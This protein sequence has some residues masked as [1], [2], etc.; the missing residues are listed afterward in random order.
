MLARLVTEVPEADAVPGGYVYEPKW[1]GFRCVVMRDG[2]QI[3]LGSRM[4]RSLTSY[5]PE[6]VEHLREHL[7]PRCAIDTELIVPIGRIGR[8]HLDWDALSDRL[9]PSLR[10]IAKL[11]EQTPAELVAFDVLA[12]E[13]RDLRHEPLSVRRRVLEDVFDAINP[14]SGLHVTAQTHSAEQAR[15]WFNGFDGYGLDGLVVKE[16]DGHYES[17]RRSWLKVKRER[18]AEV[19]VLGYRRTVRHRG[20]GRLLLGMYGADDETLYYVG[21]VDLLPEHQRL[22]FAAA[23]EDSRLTPDRQPAGIL[24]VPGESA[25]ARDQ[26]VWLRPEHVAEVEFD[27]LDGQQFR[28][29]ARFRRW[30][31][32][33]DARTCRLD[34]LEGQS[35]YDLASVLG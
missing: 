14:S 12:L 4:N 30:R 11:A 35:V 31:P 3:E 26:T 8:Q 33:R 25:L 23:L 2:D 7:P 24:G 22:E 19:V 29:A 21:C 13:D 28:H 16:W 18:T 20:V 9:H 6:V 32:D 34:Q 15:A 27:Q 5:F 10:R 17:G 1:D